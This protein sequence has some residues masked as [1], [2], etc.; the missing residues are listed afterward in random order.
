MVK[1]KLELPTDRPA[2]FEE[3][4]HR[5][6]IY[7]A[8]VSGFFRRYRTV[9][10]TL[11]V[12]VFLVLPWTNYDGQQTLFLDLAKRKFTFF[13]NTFWA[14]DGPL[15]VFPL[16]IAVFLLTFITSLFGRVW[17]GWACP[18]TVFIDFFFRR[19][20]R[21]IEGSHLERRKLDLAPMSLRKVSK[22][23]VK[24]GLF[25]VISSH[26]AHSFTAYFVGAQNLVWTTLAPPSEAW[27]LFLFVQVLT[28]I[29][30]FNFGWFREQFCIIMCPYGRLQSVLIGQ[31]TLNVSYD[32]SRGEPRKGAADPHAD[33]VNCYRCVSV[34][35]TGVDIRR[36]L[37]LECIACT[38]CMDAC[39]E[40]MVK[41]NK[42][43]GL[44][45]YMAFDGF[46][47]GARSAVYLGIIALLI[48]GL[49]Y[50]LINRKPLDFKIIRAKD[51]PYTMVQEGGEDYVLNH[52][53]VHISN[54]SQKV[55]EIDSV[56]VAPVSPDSAGS[57]VPNIQKNTG[58]FN[59]GSSGTLLANRIKII[60][61]TL[62]SKLDPGKDSWHHVFVRAPLRS[63]K[64]SKLD[65]QISLKADGVLDDTLVKPI[66]LALLG[67]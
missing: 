67:P 16:L 40:V 23:A 27:E 64:N 48:G 62:P 9:F 13:G 25:A 32:E 28:A 50:A 66:N 19:I 46:K 21:W 58:E 2:S 45:R 53:R 49:S 34:C 44:I 8:D 14:H 5:A 18:Q 10:Y 15:I 41:I 57:Q 42:P 30:L 63:F 47:F 39:D 7:P 33:C 38:A 43:R 60:T 22:K 6:Y 51:S 52:F 59:N 12:I 61:A 24:W 4:G 3:S 35:P 55:I 11:L 36:G 56:A 65:I 37:Q 29:L 54:Q 1:S 31:N 20:E 17:C 26:I